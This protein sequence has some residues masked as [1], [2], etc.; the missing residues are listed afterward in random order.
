MHGTNKSTSGRIG[1][2]SLLCELHRRGK[3][4]GPAKPAQKTA[5]EARRK[6]AAAAKSAARAVASQEWLEDVKGDAKLLRE[7]FVEF[8]AKARR[9]HCGGQ[10]CRTEPDRVARFGSVPVGECRSAT[11]ERPAKGLQAVKELLDR[12][13]E[14]IGLHS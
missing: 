3:L 13:A 2:A 7:E 9:L 12:V 8:Y 1:W 6:V 4:G 10:P 5:A 11:S 14:R